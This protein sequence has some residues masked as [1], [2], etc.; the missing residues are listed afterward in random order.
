M[1]CEK[2]NSECDC[3]G[4][5]FMNSHS[6]HTELTN[7]RTHT[8]FCLPLHTTPKNGCDGGGKRNQREFCT[9]IGL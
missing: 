2:E 9:Q 5:T 8:F 6:R 4:E 1:Y 3:L 7:K